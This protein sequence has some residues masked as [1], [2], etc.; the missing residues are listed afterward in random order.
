SEEQID[1]TV[2]DIINDV[3]YPNKLAFYRSDYLARECLIC[4]Q[5]IGKSTE[6]TKANFRKRQESRNLEQVRTSEL[7]DVWWD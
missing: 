5:E 3:I 6:E 1:N 7:D 4:I 2:D